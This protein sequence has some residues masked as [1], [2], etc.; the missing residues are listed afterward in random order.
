[1][2]LGLVVLF[3]VTFASLAHGQRRTGPFIQFSGVL[4]APAP[5]EQRGPATAF[6]GTGTLV[7]WEDLRNDVR[8]ADLFAI[9]LGPNGRPLGSPFVISSEPWA[10]QFA[11]VACQPLGVC[12]I[13]WTELAPVRRLLARTVSPSGGLSAVKEIDTD[14]V[15]YSDVAATPIGF[16][17]V[18]RRSRHELVSATFDA[19]GQANS[20][21]Q[22]ILTGSVEV[23]AWRVAATPG[24][25][26]QLIWWDNPSYHT[27]KLVDGGVTAIATLGAVQN[28][29]TTQLFVNDGAFVAVWSE[30]EDG[31][32]RT[33]I[34]ARHL[35]LDGGLR[36]PAA[37]VLASRDGIQAIFTSAP[38]GNDLLLTFIDD[39]YSNVWRSYSSNLVEQTRGL[40]NSTMAQ[41]LGLSVA[42]PPVVVRESGSSGLTFGAIDF[43]G[44]AGGLAAASGP[45]KQVRPRVVGGPDGGL[46][47]WWDNSNDAFLRAALLD[48]NGR[49]GPVQTLNEAA[50]SSARELDLVFDGQSYIVAWPNDRG[51]GI[52][53]RRLALDGRL[54]GPEREVGT[55]GFYASVAAAVVSETTSLVWSA[56]PAGGDGLFLRRLDTDGGWLD[57][58]PRNLGRNNTSP[59]GAARLGGWPVFVI[60]RRSSSSYI[61]DV[62]I[63][64]LDGDGGLSPL[65]TF[66]LEVAIIAVASSGGTLLLAW[67]EFLQPPYQVRAARFDAQGQPLDTPPLV[68]GDTLVAPTDPNHTRVAAT[69]DGVQFR[70]VWETIAADGGA[71]LNQSIIPERGPGV[72]SNSFVSSAATEQSAALATLS[73]GRVAYAYT[74]SSS[75]ALRVASGVI[76]EVPL[77]AQCEDAAECLQGTCVIG[78][79]EL[80]GGAGGGAAGG[81]GGG[82]GTAG[83]SA[84]GGSSGGEVRNGGGDARPGSFRV[85]CSCDSAPGSLLMLVLSMLAAS[86]RRAP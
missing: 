67:C 74:T 35:E 54:L 41:S 10:E 47:V 33:E 82:G 53:L 21:P 51:T 1:M 48:V 52:S 42:S 63:E 7:V 25:Q 79:C 80:A 66:P 86:R 11:S 8:R 44:D 61:I 3:A 65:S 70:V 27:G 62:S 56:S 12:L 24:G 46:L 81:A 64:R 6:D 60:G 75:T 29:P 15:D 5:F 71:D 59:L 18:W 76:A 22:S 39:S 16:R 26:E 2:R 83:G 30:L 23:S 4:H 55:E 57:T 73:P 50:V 13:I 77:G 85:G 40:V 34:K 9:R 20:M 32:Q 58:T 45:T 78:R 72:V 19:V 17:V 49:P 69:F 84:A 38:N 28:W 31:G 37:A 36:E 68:L 43:S 14:S